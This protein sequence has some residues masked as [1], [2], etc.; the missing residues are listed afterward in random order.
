MRPAVS[1]VMPFAGDPASAGE[2]ASVLKHLETQAADELILV[3]NSGTVP[4]L[5]GITVVRAAAEHSPA[6]ARNVGAEHAANEWVLFLDSDCRAPGH[7]ID[8]YFSLPIGDGVGALAGDVVAALDGQALA[9]RYGAARGFLSQQQH[10]AHP[11]RPRAVAANLLV[12]RAAFEQIG[13]FYEGLR[14]A[15]DTDFSWRLQQAG[16][17]LE[18]RPQAAVE[19]RYRASI[20]ELRRQ[21]RGYAAGRAWLA[22]RYNGFAPQ[23]AAARAASR[24]RARARR[25][26]G[27]GDY[28]VHRSAPETGAGPLERSR[29]L[30]L[31][32]LLAGEE[33]AGFVLSN[34]PRRDGGNG[35]SR[36]VLIA[37]RFPGAADPLVDFARTLDS[38]R[39]EATARP[40]AVAAEATRALRIDYREDDGALLRAAALLQLLIRHPVRSAVD[41]MRRA[42]GEPKLSALAPAVRR[43]QR[44]RGARVHA[45]GTEQARAI[46]RRVAALAGRPL[47]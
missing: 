21:W 2:A 24:V 8:A 12:R 22:R 45:L 29:Y 28:A 41:V 33:L 47:D 5:G 35:P 7:L 3:D 16:W 17:R 42:R 30:A 43:L 36:V 20:A 44:D 46:A 10:L 32:A 25:L 38:V 23:P 11:F 19:H 6:H 9:S 18:A 27:G 13:G 4:E 1:V 39:V 15:E 34:R 40:E 14:A 31:D 37:E 26:A